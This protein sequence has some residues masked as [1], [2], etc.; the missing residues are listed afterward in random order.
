M[1]G[2]PYQAMILAAGLGARLHE[3]TKAMPKALL[4]LGPRPRT[5][6]TETC[7]LRRSI[8]LLLEAEV[9]KIVVVV[10]WQRDQIIAAVEDWQLP[11][12]L[13]VNPTPDTSEREWQL[14][15]PPVRSAFRARCA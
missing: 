15:Q 3:H 5:D 13:V 10:G 12:A 1:M 2:T 6:C 14:A 9:A 7:F 4:P 8:E 11:V